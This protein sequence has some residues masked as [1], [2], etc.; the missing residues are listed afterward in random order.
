MVLIDIECDRLIASGFN[1]HS[2]QNHNLKAR[3]EH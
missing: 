2:A 3:C 1:Y